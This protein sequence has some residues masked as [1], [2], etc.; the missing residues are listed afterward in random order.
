MHCSCPDWAVPCK[1]L[2][3]VIYI[4]ANEIDRNPFIIFQLHGLDILNELAQRGFQS[5]ET[6]VHIKKL[7]EDAVERNDEDWCPL[8]K[9][10]SGVD[11]S[12]IPDLHNNLMAMLDEQ[13]LFYSGNFK[14][15]LIIAHKKIK[16]SVVTF[17]E[18]NQSIDEFAENY[19]LL[20]EFSICFTDKLQHNFTSIYS[21]NSSLVFEQD[22]FP[23][24]L[25]YLE[26]IPHKRIANLPHNLRQLHTVY[27]FAKKLLLQGAYVPELIKNKRGEYILRWVPALMN[28]HVKNIF[29]KLTQTMPGNAVHIFENEKECFYKRNEQLTLLTSQFMSF[30]MREA[31]QDF[32]KFNDIMERFFF[33]QIPYEFKALGEEEIPQTIQRWISKFHIHL[34]DFVPVIKV[35]EDENRFKIDILIENRSKPYDEPIRL[36]KFLTEET[37][38]MAKTEVLKDLTLLTSAFPQ[39]EFT[40]QTSGRHSLQFNS[41]EFSNVLMQILPLVKMYGIRILLPNSLKNIIRPKPTLKLAQQSGTENNKGFL[42][43]DKMLDFQWQVALGDK[44][45]EPEAFMAM[46]EGLSGVVKLHNQYILIDHDEIEKLQRSL[47]KPLILKTGE[48]IQTALTEEYEGAKIELTPEARELLDYFLKKEHVD[49]PIGL[50]ATLRPYQKRG[51]AWMYTNTNTGIGSIIADDMGL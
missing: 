11:F 47:E 5:E 40:V 31:A 50:Q 48:L 26:R 36:E 32:S 42:S 27:T 17:T 7:T 34:K 20:Q 8:S 2:A 51:Y 19:A 10:F 9:D 33:Y 6:G 3:S 37:Q 14:E 4:I 44:I 21:R 49:P 16:K 45:T 12:K 1:H 18:K 30:F 28:D 41:N 25:S 23:E 24:L 35:E 22:E 29:D 13:C 39:L 46:V 38:N 43:L 15:R